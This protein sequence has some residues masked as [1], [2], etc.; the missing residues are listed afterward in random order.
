MNNTICY[1]ALPSFLLPRLERNVNQDKPESSTEL[2]LRQWELTY[3]RGHWIGPAS[4][5][6]N[7]ITFI[8]AAQTSPPSVKSLYYIAAACAGGA[9]PFT[10][11]FILSTNN[12]LYRRADLLRAQTTGDE[13]TGMLKG[14]S[15]FDAD[16]TLTL[17][18]KCHFWSTIRAWMPFPA[19]VIAL[20]AIARTANET[21]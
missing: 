9:F 16:G 14:K 12:E 15:Q 4:A 10:V 19:I 11:L 5:V 8:Y 2:I 1:I 18:R 17:I 20:Y 21:N 3:S 13:R 6:I 7:A